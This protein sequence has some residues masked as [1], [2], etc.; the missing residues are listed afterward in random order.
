M[1]L[2][3]KQSRELRRLT[4]HFLLITIE[5]EK[6]KTHH[7]YKDDRYAN[8]RKNFLLN[9][10]QLCVLRLSPPVKCH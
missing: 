7:H 4:V 3:S 2:E 6:V 10:E 8:Q 1:K 9:A 5:D